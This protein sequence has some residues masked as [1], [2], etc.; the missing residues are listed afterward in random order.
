MAKIK[1]LLQSIIG[2]FRQMLLSAKTIFVM[3]GVEPG[4]E[5]RTRHEERERETEGEAREQ[6]RKRSRAEQS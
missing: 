5:E 6:K 3:R 2:S 1:R 4:R